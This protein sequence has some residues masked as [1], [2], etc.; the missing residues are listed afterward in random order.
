MKEELI[1]VNLEKVP[2]LLRKFSSGELKMM[3]FIKGYMQH[4]RKS[5]FVN[6]KEMRDFAESMNFKRTS[7]GYSNLLNSLVNKG[8][9]SKEARG[10]Y[11]IKEDLL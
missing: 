8:F 2:E 5:V 11:T 4:T 10:V 6:N 1:A 9:L 3:L 7:V